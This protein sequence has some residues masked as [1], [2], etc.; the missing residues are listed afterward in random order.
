M[1]HFVIG[2]MPPALVI[3]A[4]SV[5]EGVTFTGSEAE[6]VLENGTAQFAPST[7]A[8]DVVTVTLPLLGAVGK[9][10]VRV[11][12]VAPGVRLSL[13]P[14]PVVVEYDDGAGWHTL[15]SA[16]EDWDGA[17]KG[18]DADDARLYDLLQVA[19]EQV[20]AFAPAREDGDPVPTR[21]R[22]A[23]IM[24]ARNL[25]NAIRKNPATDTQGF[26]EFSVPSFPLDW[27]VRSLIRPIRAVP[28]V[29]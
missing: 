17:P 27:H 4:A 25:W 18:D 5:P 6:F 1:T 21:Y 7:I 13:P 28:V 2:D 9:H 24:Q 26:G 10:E 20:L 19:R 8:D 22:A 12:L 16:R 3:D 23:Q 29:G 15:T 11:V 14:I